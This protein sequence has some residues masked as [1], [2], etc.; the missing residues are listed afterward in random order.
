MEH[1]K[2][3][4]VGYDTVSH[5]LLVCFASDTTHSQNPEDYPAV[6]INPSQMWP[7]VTDMEEIKTKIAEVGVSIV[8]Q[9]I[10]KESVIS[11]P[12]K[13]IEYQKLVGATHQFDAADLMPIVTEPVIHTTEPEF[14]DS[15]NP[16]NH[17]VTEV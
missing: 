16:H 8:Q 9:Q 11:N 7:D 14:V 5:S 2:Y 3:K 6:A 4:I 12:V 15:T 13:Q 17:P 1:V 10:A